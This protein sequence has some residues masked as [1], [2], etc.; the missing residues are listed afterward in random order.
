MKE[1]RPFILKF[2]DTCAKAMGSD[3]RK[4]IIFDDIFESSVNIE[5]SA[6]PTSAAGTA[7]AT[8]QLNNMVSILGSGSIA[9]LPI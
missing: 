4:S 8:S 9:G 5:A 1:F 2:L 6:Q 3:D 7:G